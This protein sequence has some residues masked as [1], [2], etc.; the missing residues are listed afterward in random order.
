MEAVQEVTDNNTPPT[1]KEKNDAAKYLTGRFYKVNEQG[2]QTFFYDAMTGNKRLQKMHL[3]GV[4]QA[5]GWEWNDAME[6]VNRAWYKPLLIQPIYR[7]E[8]PP[9]LQQGGIYYP[10]IWRRPTV[11]PVESDSDPFVKHLTLMLGS[12]EKAQYLVRMLAYRYQNP[13]L[14]SKPHIA[15]YFYGEQGGMGKSLFA[16]TITQVFG[17]SAVMSCVDQSALTS[18]SKIDMFSRTWCFVQEVDVKKGD[19]N[20]NTIKTHTGGDYF[21]DARKGEHFRRHETPAQLIMLSNSAPHFIEPTDRRFFIS[22]WTHDFDS[23]E[24]KNKYFNDYVGWLEQEGGYEAIAYLLKT[25]DISGVDVAAAAPMTP[26]KEQIISMGGDDCVADIKDYLDAS[27]DRV[28]FDEDEFTD[29]LSRHDAIK[30][31]KYKL[32]AAG[33]S[34]GETRINKVRR[35]FWIRE[36]HTQVSKSGVPAVIVYPDRTEKPVSEVLPPLLENSL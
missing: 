4:L 29:I 34:K 30:A 25:T 13:N 20:Y 12:R 5:R 16:D 10:N 7:P 19:T 1:K 36:G 28:L 6:I 35:R 33:L 23:A 27:P 11:E 8:M 15:F 31:A 32:E 21:D 26:E 17:D 18:M 14:T 9:V 3:Y 2:N 24:A 22:K